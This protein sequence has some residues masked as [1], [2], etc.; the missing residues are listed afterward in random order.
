MALADGRSFQAEWR[1]RRQALEQAKEKLDGRIPWQSFSK[2]TLSWY[3]SKL[4]DEGGNPQEIVQAQLLDD[5]DHLTKSE[6]DQLILVFGTDDSVRKVLGRELLDLRAVKNPDVRWDERFE[7]HANIIECLRKSVDFFSRHV[8]IDGMTLD[9]L[10]ATSGSADY[11]AMR[12][13]LVNMFIHQDFTDDSAAAQVEIG[14]EKV[15]CFNTGK[16]LVKRKTRIRSLR[17]MNR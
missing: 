4:S 11:L 17:E 9:G 2:E 6:L 15:V 3:A 12:E 10:K 1:E 13:A 5:R 7:S 16:S 8:G 14:P